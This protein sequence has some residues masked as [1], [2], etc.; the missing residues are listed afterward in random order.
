MRS[1]RP[2]RHESLESRRLLAAKLDLGG[3]DPLHRIPWDSAALP[4]DPA[5]LKQAKAI[6]GDSDL[7]EGVKNLDFVAPL[8]YPGLSNGPDLVQEVGDRLFV[9]DQSR[10]PEPGGKLLVFHQ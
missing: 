3:F 8:L 5:D 10:G 9:V 2:L 4:W 6:L 1:N 7:L